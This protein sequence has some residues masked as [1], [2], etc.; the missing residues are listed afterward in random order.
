MDG[1]PGGNERLH[2]LLGEVLEGGYDAGSAHPI[3]YLPSW[4][5][6]EALKARLADETGTELYAEKMRNLVPGA[7]S[8][9]TG[10]GKVTRT[11]LRCKYGRARKTRA[12]PSGRKRKRASIKLGC[13]LSISLWEFV[14]A[15][16]AL[17]PSKPPSR[18]TNLETVLAAAR[19]LGYVARRH[20]GLGDRDILYCL[21][22]RVKSLHTNH[23]PT[24]PATAAA[25]KAAVPLSK[26]PTM[27]V[28]D[29]TTAG[30][31]ATTA[32]STAP[33]G[34]PLPNIIS[35][36]SFVDHSS[37]SSST[38][39]YPHKRSRPLLPSSSHPHLHLS[40]PPRE[41][42]EIES[43]LVLTSSHPPP[44]SHPHPHPHPHPHH[45][46]VRSHAHPQLPAA[47]SG[48][49]LRLESR[50][51]LTLHHPLHHAHHN[52]HNPHHNPHNPHHNPHNPH[53]AHHN[54]YSP[55]QVNHGVGGEREDGNVV[56][57]N[58][59]V[60]D[61]PDDEP[62]DEEEDDE[63]D[64]DDEEEEDDEVESDSDE[65]DSG[66]VVIV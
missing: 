2:S 23:D 59:R 26:A 17:P 62:D 11:L 21:Q 35:V 65:S 51:N 55:Q 60:L 32:T 24:A 31:D 36:T 64:D 30:M 19:A 9:A 1:T 14:F 50:E 49:G 12:G 5:A 44:S 6:W 53:H 46:H 22:F 41:S 42:M 48:E 29:A 61:E 10:T 47:A 7:D 37:S 52:P 38:N 56:S 34:I 45:P 39:H 8:L 33:L 16:D 66:D 40:P 43:P 54:P 20:V 18:H 25:P 57:G 63:D 4:E 3:G 15:P 58:D 28:L 27:E 13:T